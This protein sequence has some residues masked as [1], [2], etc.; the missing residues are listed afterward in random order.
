VDEGQT[1]IDA[2]T[3][4]GP[5]LLNGITPQFRFVITNTGDVIITDITVTDSVLGLIG[6]LPSLN[7]G[8]TFEWII[9]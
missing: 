2:N 6:T 9:A 5:H 3:P 8:A 7:P 1:W 4:P